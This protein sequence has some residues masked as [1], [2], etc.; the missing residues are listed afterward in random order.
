MANLRVEGYREDQIHLVGNV[1]V[2]TLLA[3]LERARERPVLGALGLTARLV[4][5]DS[6]DEETRTC[7]SAARQVTVSTLVHP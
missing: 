1:M 3:N 6:V 2:D 5:T 4:F 7:R